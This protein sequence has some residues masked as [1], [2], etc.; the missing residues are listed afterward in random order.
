M[1]VQLYKNKV[2][3]S[4]I[5]AT[6]FGR[7]CH[8]PLQATTDGNLQVK[9]HTTLYKEERTQS[10]GWLRV[11]CTYIVLSCCTPLLQHS[12]NGIFSNWST[13]MN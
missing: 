7:A 13:E 9:F 3:S 6:Y 4:Q 1:E 2:K 12:S 8:L 10:D 11:F 5:H